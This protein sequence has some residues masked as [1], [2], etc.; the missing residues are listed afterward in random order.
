MIDGMGM[1]GPIHLSLDYYHSYLHASHTACM[2]WSGSWYSSYIWSCSRELILLPG[3]VPDRVAY[4]CGL[5]LICSCCSVCGNEGTAG[6]LSATV[7]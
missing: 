7:S 1:H 5:L 3:F 2:W 4:C 6:R